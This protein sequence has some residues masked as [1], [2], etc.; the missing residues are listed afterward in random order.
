MHGRVAPTVGEVVRFEE[1]VRMRRRRVA[2]AL[3]A[4]CRVIL[5]ASVEAARVACAQGPAAE[6]WVRVTRLRKLEELQAYA[7]ELG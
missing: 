4:R 2:Q 1:I 3:H 5:A 7:G 6:R